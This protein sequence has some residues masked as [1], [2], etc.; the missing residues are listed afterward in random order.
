MKYRHGDKVWVKPLQLEG[1]VVE[2]KT[3]T[4]V[5]R[6]PHNGDLKEHEFEL[7]DVDRLPTTK[8]AYYE[9]NQ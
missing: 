6:V 2:E 3:R 8:E 1:T 5:V 4:V 9:R 7:E